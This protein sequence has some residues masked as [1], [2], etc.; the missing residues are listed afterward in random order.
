[1]RIDPAGTKF[2]DRAGADPSAVIASQ[3]RDDL[4][5]KPSTA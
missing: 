2:W 1:M 4:A 3:F 5:E